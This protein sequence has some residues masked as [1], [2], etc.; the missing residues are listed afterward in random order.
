M[1][2]SYPFSFTVGPDG[3]VEGNVQATTR[4][5]TIPESEFG[6]C[7][8]SSLPTFRLRLRGNATGGSVTLIYTPVGKE[9]TFTVDCSSGTQTL[10]GDYV[11]RAFDLAAG[12]QLTVP[13]VGGGKKAWKDNASGEHLA[14]T[15]TIFPGP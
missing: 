6:P 4:S 13:E 10:S 1:T 5:A 11:K 3:E 15:V 2:S 14:A 7:S 8:A 12:L 9:P